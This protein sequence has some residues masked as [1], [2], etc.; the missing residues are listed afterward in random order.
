[1]ILVLPEIPD[2]KKLRKVI[3]IKQSSKAI[4]RGSVSKLFLAADADPKLTGP[5]QQVCKAH[6][7]QIVHVGSMEELGA[8]CGIDVGAAAVAL[9]E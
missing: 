8:A 4:E 1:V 9:L 5:L 6:G 2:L 7:I 3:G